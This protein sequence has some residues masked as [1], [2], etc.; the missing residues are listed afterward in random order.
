MCAGVSPNTVADV[1]AYDA[2]RAEK[3]AE[4]VDYIAYYIDPGFSAER[5]ADEI[6]STA[7]EMGRIHGD[8]INGEVASRYTT[9]GRPLAFTI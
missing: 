2:A 4:I 9:D 6:L 8:E 1:A 7:E 5:I 3:L